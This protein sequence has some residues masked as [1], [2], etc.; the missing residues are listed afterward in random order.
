M[1][2]PTSL[3]PLSLYIHVPWCV[4]KCPYCDFNSHSVNGEL[5]IDHYVDCLLQDANQDLG[6]AQQRPLESIF[7]GGG[8]PSLLP[9]HAVA[10]LLHGLREILPFADHCEITLETNPGTAEYDNFSRYRD[11]GVNRLSLGAQSFSAQQLQR[12]GRIH[13]PDDTR[14]AF[15]LARQAGFDNINLD[16]M[17]ALPEQTLTQALDDLNQAIDLAPEH[18]SWYQL[19]I[20]PNTAFYSQPPSLPDDDSSWAI[21]QSGQQRLSAA[22]YQQYE[23]SA[24]AR[25]GKVAYHNRN[26]W[27]F[28]DY[29]A[30]GAGAHGK[31]TLADSGEIFRYQKTRLPEHYLAAATSR[32][33]TAQKT[34][35][36]AH[37]LPFEFMMNALR[38]NAGVEARLYSERTGLSLDAM[39]LQLAEL[40]RQGLL[41]DDVTRLAATDLGRQ[42]LNSLLEKLLPD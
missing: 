27:Q 26:Y 34:P 33:F 2:K 23:I 1:T 15:S 16:L 30:I 10:R 6:F 28:G 19:T 18:L 14:Q 38:L 3:P 32:R 12:L 41:S 36:S 39:T 31:I 7:F 25:A 5:P 20:E 11:A 8:T 4:R 35:L 17:F 13:Q 21:Q 24:Y 22:G 42:Y 29:M 40:R 37:N 9:G